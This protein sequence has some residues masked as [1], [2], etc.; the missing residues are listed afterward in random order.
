MRP[1]VTEKAEPGLSPAGQEGRRQPPSFPA[2]GRLRADTPARGGRRKELCG[3]AASG[4]LSLQPLYRMGCCLW[5]PGLSLDWGIAPEGG[6]AC[7]ITRLQEAF[8]EAPRF[9]TR[10]SMT[11]GG[12]WP[13]FQ[14]SL[15]APGRFQEDKHMVLRRASCGSHQGLCDPL[16][17]GGG[18][19][20]RTERIPEKPPQWPED[21]S[22]RDGSWV[23]EAASW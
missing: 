5:G 19:A 1:S 20:R 10:H 22:L 21:R 7:S 17:D 4:S 6:G 3:P 11:Q 13:P 14:T 9:L 2:L 16:L 15:P 18:A 12:T 8:P 23:M